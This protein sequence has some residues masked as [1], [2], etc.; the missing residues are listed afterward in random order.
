MEEM[1]NQTTH[2]RYLTEAGLQLRRTGFQTEEPR[3]GYMAVLWEGAPLCRVTGGGGAQYH[4]EDIAPDNRNDAFHKLLDITRR[5]SEYMRLMETG[6]KLE[7]TGLH[8]DYR[9]LAEFNG[10]VLAGHKFTDAPG[11]Q[12]VTWERD[13]DRTGVIYGHYTQDYAAAKEDF[14][15]RSGLVQKGRRFSDEQLA[16]VYRCIYET[17][18]SEYP[19]TPQREKLLKDTAA[20]I[21][22]VV[23][24]LEQRVD[25][26][27]LQEL[28]YAAQDQEQQML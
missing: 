25:Q 12:F 5:V 16:E 9:M 6:P 23:T 11:H 21:E 1:N 27:N 17:L 28:E 7:A 4:A 8:E 18:G 24:D 26:S 15:A 14:A 3:D 20:Q 10:I 2:G 22:D 13:Y 19:I